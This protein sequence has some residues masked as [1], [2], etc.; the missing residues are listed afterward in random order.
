MPVE[1]QLAA[2]SGIGLLDF[3]LLKLFN[4]GQQIRATKGKTYAKA[5]VIKT[6]LTTRILMFITSN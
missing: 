5:G 3:Y 4:N 2:F 6:V 1:Y